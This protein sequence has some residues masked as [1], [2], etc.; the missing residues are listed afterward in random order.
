MVVV[1]KGSPSQCG[2]PSAQSHMSNRV[3]GLDIVQQQRASLEGMIQHVVRKV[4][5]RDPER[6]IDERVCAGR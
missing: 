4:F 3:S 6:A 2:H 1:V 5:Y